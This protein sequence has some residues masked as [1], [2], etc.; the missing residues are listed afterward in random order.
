MQPL[1]K[2][3][4]LVEDSTC[5]TLAC[6]LLED[7]SHADV[8]SKQWRAAL[9]DEALWRRHVIARAQRRSRDDDDVEPLVRWRGS[10]RTTALARA[11]ALASRDDCCDDASESETTDDDA[12]A[13][14]GDAC[15]R[16]C[17]KAARPARLA[18]A[19]A[20]PADTWA[21]AALAKRRPNRR[22][23]CVAQGEPSDVTML[24]RDY[25][26]YVRRNADAEPLMVIDDR[27]PQ[28][29]TC[30]AYP[31]VAPIV[32]GD[33]LAELARRDDVE[34][35]AAADLQRERKYVLWGGAGA[36]SRWHV[37]P[38]GTDAW[39]ALLAGRKRWAFY[40]PGATPPGV[41][42]VPRLVSASRT[43]WTTAPAAADWFA[44]DHPDIEIVTQEA[45]DVVYVPAGWWHAT[46]CETP[47]VAITQNV[48][49]AHNARAAHA[50]M[51]RSKPSL[52]RELAALVR[53][54]RADDE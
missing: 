16:R 49:F 9:S 29:G 40:P 10:W 50:L 17:A 30:T 18:A 21:V 12:A 41:D 6:S 47:C 48:I 34:P 20:P 31:A 44:R 19:F 27:V 13:I 52:A 22:L 24:A 4:K 35:A 23:R 33:H 15:Q 32:A 43:L 39:N 51:A 46:L 1:L 14:V 5:V 36:G 38:Y 28:D 2:K 26:A 54:R 11:T 7:L 53:R 25:A 8:V 3:R 42:I 45:G 37:D